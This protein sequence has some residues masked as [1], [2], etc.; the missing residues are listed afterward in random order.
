MNARFT[1]RESVAPG[2]YTFYF[3]P[4]QPM[5]Y[6]AGQFTELYL[7]NL[8]GQ[9]HEFTLSSSP[10]EPALAIT[11]NIGSHPSSYKQAMLALEPGKTVHL[12]EPMGD[13]VL[14]KDPS[15]PLVF[16]AGGLGITPV[17]SIVTW[18]KERGEQRDIHLFYAA[19][20]PQTVIFQN[21]FTGLPVTYLVSEPDAHWHDDVGHMS[22]ERILA[23]APIDALFYI[24]GPESFVEAIHSDLQRHQIAGDRLVTDR[25]TG[26]VD[27]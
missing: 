2:I 22:A 14:P 17:R 3:E 16:V 26:Y 27:L 13:F 15:I 21:V 18:L 10:S 25:F 23:N 19:K 8:P 4:E 24:A 12:L 11:V 20:K 5:R 6:D 7:P 9:M 1:R